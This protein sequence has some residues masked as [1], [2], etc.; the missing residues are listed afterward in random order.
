MTKVKGGI[1]KKISVMT[2]A[3]FVGSILIG[4]LA[5]FG[6][7]GAKD[8]KQTDVSTR[9]VLSV[10]GAGVVKAKPDMFTVTLTINTIDKSAR[11]AQQQ[12]DTKANALIEALRKFGIK[13]E[14]METT[15]YSLNP[16][17]RWD[18]DT[19][20]SILDGYQASYSLNVTANDLKQTGE[21]IDLATNKGVNQIG[22]IVM[23]IKNRQRLADEA[24]RLAMKDAKNKAE[25]ALGEVNLKILSVNSISIGYNEPMV[26]NEKATRDAAPGASGGGGVA[27]EMIAGQL[28]IY[29]SVYIEFN[30]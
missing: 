8:S 26:A 12:N 13:D 18:K 24:L 2:I 4:S 6:V 7:A 16:H 11:E 27:P 9:N 20:E 21:V 23:G 10:S 29:A 14:D 28:S 5:A 25:I 22:S 17:Y 3:I 19:G 1:M 15:N 30:Y